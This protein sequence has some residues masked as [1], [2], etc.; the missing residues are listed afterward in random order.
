M[1]V[2]PVRDYLVLLGVSGTEEEKKDLVFT[3][4]FEE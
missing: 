2:F 1:K 3:D 4:T